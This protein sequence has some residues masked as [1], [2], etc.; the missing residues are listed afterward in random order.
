MVLTLLRVPYDPFQVYTHEASSIL[1]VSVT[2]FAAIRDNNFEDLDSSSPK[3]LVAQKYDSRRGH[4]VHHSTTFW[5]HN[6]WRCLSLECETPQPGV[7]DKVS[8]GED[9]VLPK[10]YQCFVTR[11]RPINCAGVSAPW[12]QRTERMD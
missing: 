7:Q 10:C 11:L 8:V 1:T 6:S 5:I 9:A 4:S 3:L 12:M 2:E